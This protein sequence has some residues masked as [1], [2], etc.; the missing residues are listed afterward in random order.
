MIGARPYGSGQKRSLDV[1]AAALFACLIN[2]SA[3]MAQDPKA[4]WVTVNFTTIDKGAS[5]THGLK[6]KRGTAL[7][8]G[9]QA[10][11]F[12]LGFI[13]KTVRAKNHTR[14][15]YP[16]ATPITV[17]KDAQVQAVAVGPRKTR[18]RTNSKVIVKGDQITEEAV[19]Y[20]SGRQSAAIKWLRDH[21][22]IA[23]GVN[24][25]TVNLYSPKGKALLSKSATA[26]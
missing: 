5:V 23:G 2:L 25:G 12:S 24:S 18:A 22:N 14:R 8:L 16:G 19:I 7:A 17:Q 21:T 11:S 20:F 10:S 6:M 13:E 9:L 1:R 4:T 3:V 26:A 15:L